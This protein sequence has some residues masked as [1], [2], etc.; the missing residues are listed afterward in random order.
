MHHSFLKMT[1]YGVI[2]KQNRPFSHLR[3]FSRQLMHANT[4]F[5]HDKNHNNFDLE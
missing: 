4:A 5:S 2:K 1:V 3:V